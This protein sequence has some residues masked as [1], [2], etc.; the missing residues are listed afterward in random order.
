M[1]PKFAENARRRAK[2][3]AAAH[4][5]LGSRVRWEISVLKDDKNESDRSSS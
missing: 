2:Q 5:H 3:F 4:V 1:W